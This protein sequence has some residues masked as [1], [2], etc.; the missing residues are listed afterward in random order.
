MG[1]VR[2]R[3]RGARCQ[4]GGGVV[5]ADEVRYM[6]RD[7]GRTVEWNPAGDVWLRASVL[8]ERDGRLLIE[9]HE[10]GQRLTVDERHT[11]RVDNLWEITI[12]VPMWLSGEQRQELFSAVA[13]AVHDWEPDYRDGWDADVSGRPAAER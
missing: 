10:Q 7:Q 5:S 1:A 4:A 8:D 3:R 11:R 9:L 12:R 6:S 13:E 2:Q